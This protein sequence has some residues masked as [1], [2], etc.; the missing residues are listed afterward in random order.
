[1]TPRDDQG[2][3]VIETSVIIRTFNE[4][5]H[6]P[7]LFDALD[8]QNYRDFE[9]IVV[10][11][12]SND[13]TRDI[14]EAR[15]DKVLRI[16][17]HDFTFGFSLN[18]GIR[19]A[20]GKYIAII[21][22]H[23]L[24]RDPDWLKNLIAPLADS[25]NSI[26][27]GRQLG[28]ASSKFGE[29]EDFERVFGARARFDKAGDYRVNNANSAIRRE[30]W[31]R[32]PFDE[33]LTG[34][35]DIAWAKSWAEEGLAVAYVPE[36]AVFHV[37]EE[38][39]RQ[40][41]T[42]YYREAVAARRIGIKSLRWVPREILKEFVA[43]IGDLGHVMRPNGN[44]VLQRL[45]RSQCVREIL[46][47]RTHK[48]L[49]TIKGLM[50]AHA[51]E[52]RQEVED[53]LFDRSARAV[54]IHGPGKAALE[55]RPLPSVRPGEVLV[56]VSHVAVC[57]TDIEVFEGKLGY[58][59]NGMAA[60]PIVPG[61]EFSGRI[62]AHGQNVV[63]LAE[64]DR[65]VVECIQGCGTCDQCSNG[66][67]IGCLERGEVGVMGRDGAYADYLVTPARFV[68]KLPAGLDMRTAALTEPLAV[69]LKGLRRI[70]ASHHFAR[71]PARCGVIGAGPLGR[72]CAK[73]LARR[74][75]SVTVFDRNEWRL[76]LFDDGPIETSTDLN[77]LANCEVIAEITGD[78]GVLETALKVSPSDALFLLLGLPYGER[79]FSFET[80]AAYDKTVIGSVGSTGED[81]KQ[82]LALL[83]QLDLSEYF[84]ATLPLAEFEKAWKLSKSGKVLKVILDVA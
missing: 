32:S 8:T 81:F 7:A 15:A 52:T 20:K 19:E 62:V 41:Q 13:Q 54:V 84:A 68:H 58:Y 30:L 50:R 24:P 75:H 53:V 14:A 83:P 17:S 82:A 10:D 5:K 34:L 77:G 73:V 44:P 6:L 63:G 39:W 60:Y 72:L 23:A 16:S 18:T 71:G 49:G 31:R 29:A 48:T 69:V 4:E 43:L 33:L 2:S 80:I 11:S 67:Q 78:P 47:F 66:N 12:G 55:D 40:V 45:K 64:N 25:E 74:G 35:E 65:I 61:H 57:A 9:T 46:Q 1:M 36:A 42:R 22:A 21:S 38:S 37:H 56:R 76:S 51:M 27:Y 79:P 28:A 70:G 59:K 26:A 3:K